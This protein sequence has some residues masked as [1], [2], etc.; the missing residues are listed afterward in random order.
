MYALFINT[1]WKKIFIF[2][3]CVRFGELVVQCAV[4]LQNKTIMFCKTCHK[5]LCKLFWRQIL[6]YW[7]KL[8]KTFFKKWF[9]DKCRSDQTSEWSNIGVIK[10][11]SLKMFLFY[12]YN[13]TRLL[14]SIAA[15]ITE[16][17]EKR[18]LFH[19]KNVFINVKNQQV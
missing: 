14:A 1:F 15:N 9:H 3:S 19:V 17:T 10:R 2:K 5:S 4:L 13:Y 18:K 6:R 8:K 7:V 11:R 12:T 16:F